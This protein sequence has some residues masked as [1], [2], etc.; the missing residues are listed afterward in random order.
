MLI[1]LN[2]IEY[3]KKEG[4]T[5]QIFVNQIQERVK[6]SLAVH[7]DANLELLK[8]KKKGIE[9]EII[10]LKKIANNF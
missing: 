3:L 1:A 4:K 8:L 6:N 10:E 5:N 7:S 2:T 9:K